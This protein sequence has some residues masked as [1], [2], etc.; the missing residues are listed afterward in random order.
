MTKKRVILEMGAGNDLHGGDYTK[1]ALR[2]VDDALHHS[3]LTMLRTL[4]VDPRTAM[5]VDVTIGVQQPDEVDRAAVQAALPYGTVTVDVVKGGLDVPDEAI[6]DV[7]V[8]AS[9]AVV[10]SLDLS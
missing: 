10:V 7:A 3:S 4:G 1:A 2:A 8:I 9:A 6:G 5:F